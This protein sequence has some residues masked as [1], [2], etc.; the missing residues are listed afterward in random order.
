VAVDDLSF[1]VPPGQMTGFL[2]PN[3]A[4]KCTTMRLILSLDS[5]TSRSGPRLLQ[6]VDLSSR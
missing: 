4:G 3:G 6:M 5:P 2:G 1:T